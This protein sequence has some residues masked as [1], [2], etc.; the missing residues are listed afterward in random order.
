MASVLSPGIE[1]GKDRCSIFS[2]PWEMI[3]DG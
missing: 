1:K 3:L 2:H